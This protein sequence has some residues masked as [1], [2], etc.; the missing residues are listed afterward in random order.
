MIRAGPRVDGV[1]ENPGPRCGSRVPKV[2]HEDSSISQAK[3]QDYFLRR[4]HRRIG[5]GTGLRQK[6]GEC[7]HQ[8]ALSLRGFRR[9]DILR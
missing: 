1:L 9:L 8:A 7:C 3:G 6:R 2:Q 4:C 5:S